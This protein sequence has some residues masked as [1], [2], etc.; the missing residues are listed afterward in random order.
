M[1]RLTMTVARR[2]DVVTLLRLIQR[3]GLA[4]YHCRWRRFKLQDCAVPTLDVGG[5]RLVRYPR[6]LNGH[7]LWT[8]RNDL[9]DRSFSDI[10]SAD[11]NLS[12]GTITIDGQYSIAMLK[13]HYRRTV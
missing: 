11:D 1:M 9:F 12:I 7:L 10:N 4:C 5:L 13:H 6:R 2:I 8:W 3:R